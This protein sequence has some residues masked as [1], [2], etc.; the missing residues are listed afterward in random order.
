MQMCSWSLSD[1]GWD[2][3]HIFWGRR[4]AAV[5]LGSVAS[6]Q[7]ASLGWTENARDSS[8][9]PTRHIEKPSVP[10]ARTLVTSSK[11]F[12]YQRGN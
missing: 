12:M 8:Q 6:H 3:T 4:G 5:E 10:R 9:L 7:G 2:V 11:P 1:A